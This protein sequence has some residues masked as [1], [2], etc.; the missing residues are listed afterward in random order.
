MWHCHVV[1]NTWVFMAAFINLWTL[2]SG[3]WD[4]LQSLIGGDFRFVKLP[5]TL[6]NLTF[7]ISF[8]Q[9]LVDVTWPETLQSLTFGSEFNQPLDHVK[10]PNSLQHLTFGVEFNQSLEN[11]ILPA[12]LQCLTFGHAFNQS[13]RNVNLPSCLQSLTFKNRHFNGKSLEDATLPRGLRNLSLGGMCLTCWSWAI[14]ETCAVIK[15]SKKWG[16]GW[17]LFEEDLYLHKG[18]WTTAMSP[19]QVCG[20]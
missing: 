3:L 10:L 6:R 2:Y 4:N 9:S 19:L 1:F 17:S 12:D 11:V 5:K 18:L 14:H 20:R 13:L 15:T 16:G 7:G 8:N